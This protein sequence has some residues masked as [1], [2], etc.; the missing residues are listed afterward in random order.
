MLEFLQDPLQYLIVEYSGLWHFQLF[1]QVINDS[2]DLSNTLEMPAWWERI[3]WGWFWWQ[4]VKW[5]YIK[6]RIF[7]ESIASE[8]MS[9]SFR[10]HRQGPCAFEFYIVLV[11]KGMFCT[12][13]N[14]AKEFYLRISEPRLWEWRMKNLNQWLYSFMMKPWA[15]L[16]KNICDS[17]IQEV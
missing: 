5:S 8:P 3:L 17:H 4:P 13:R 10:F 14:L 15:L 2:V 16:P 7:G 9:S 6:R 12:F 1:F 11:L